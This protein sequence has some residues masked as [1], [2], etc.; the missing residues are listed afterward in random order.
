MFEEVG[1]EI[2]FAFVVFAG[3][4]KV[5]EVKGVSYTKEEL[6]VGQYEEL[7]GIIQ[8]QAKRIEVLE[9]AAGVKERIVAPDHRAAWEWAQSQGLVNGKNPNRPL[10]REQFATIEHRKATKK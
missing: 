8:S 4:K 2:A 7:K 5:S 9:A 6:T 1:R 3:L 10:T